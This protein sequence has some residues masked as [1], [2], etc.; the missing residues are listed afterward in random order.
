M[1]ASSADAE[2]E[3]AVKYPNEQ[4]YH[5]KPP[6][7]LSDQLVSVLVGHANSKTIFCEIIRSNVDENCKINVGIGI[8]AEKV[9]GIAER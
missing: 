1:R 5:D 7:S 9:S 3:S 2:T 8:G 4:K 6:Y